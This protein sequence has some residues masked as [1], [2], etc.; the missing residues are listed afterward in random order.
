MRTVLLIAV[1]EA[2]P[3]VGVLRARYDAAEV[4]GIP[5]T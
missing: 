1:P 2:E 4:N 5:A 3:H